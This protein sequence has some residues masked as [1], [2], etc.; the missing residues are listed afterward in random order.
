MRRFKRPWV[1]GIGSGARMDVE[2][3]QNAGRRR[4]NGKRKT[5]SQMMLIWDEPDSDLEDNG[6][7]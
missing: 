7:Q 5:G 2:V 1:E 6:W 4:P 3:T